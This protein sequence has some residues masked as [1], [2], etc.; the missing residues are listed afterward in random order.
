[1]T[2]G[3][4]IRCGL[5][6]GTP[7]RVPLH[8][9]IRMA[10]LTPESQWIRDLGWGVLQ[11]H[12]GFV[13]SVDGCRQKRIET[14][15]GDSPC[16][17]HALDTP[18]GCL[19]SL[20]VPYAHGGT[21]TLEHLFK[22][23]EDYPA[24][25]AMVRAIR[26]EPA[27]DAFS[28]AAERVGKAGY[29][30]TA[31]GK[32]PMH[33]IMMEMMGI[34]TFCY[35]WADRRE[36]VLELYEALAEKHREMYGILR[37]PTGIFYAQGVKTNVLFF[38]RGATETGSTAEVWVYDLRS[39]M[40]S[41]GKRNP[42]TRDHFAEFESAFGDDPT[43][44]PKALLKRTDTGAT[45]RFRRF[46]RQEIADRGDNLDIAWLQGDGEVSAEDLP[47]PEC[48][49]K[50]AIIELES[51]LDGLRGILAELGEYAGEEVEA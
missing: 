46:S 35:E 14:M 12:P 5:M 15:H 7:D 3:E 41:F 40:P 22:G 48:L 37:L 44:C 31:A 2:L 38:T 33:K 32:D 25:M 26:Y 43:G 19:S 27:Y 9:R 18:A 1:V 17:R 47:E 13:E 20:T 28:Q 23:P 49:V 50:D 29:C 39:N 24:L 42:L 16:T 11:S 6:G 45:G 30:Y 34:E 4:R 10:P 51:A 21:F 36:R 8:C